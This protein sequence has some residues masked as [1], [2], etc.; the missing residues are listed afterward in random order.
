MP[1]QAFAECDE[2]YERLVVLVELS[3]NRVDG[4]VKIVEES[5]L[6]IFGLFF[7]G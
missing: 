5:F 2:E 1:A 3:H 6:F 7:C 4:L